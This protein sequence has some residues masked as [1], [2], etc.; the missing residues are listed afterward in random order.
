MAGHFAPAVSG[1]ITIGRSSVSQHF[2]GTDPGVGT[3]PVRDLAVDYRQMNSI[4]FLFW[5][6]VGCR[7]D[8]GVDCHPS[9]RSESA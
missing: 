9:G 7:I 6:V 2:A 1:G 3:V 4:G 5:I 8:Y